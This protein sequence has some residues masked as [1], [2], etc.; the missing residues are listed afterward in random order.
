MLASTVLPRLA[1]GPILRLLYKHSR[2]YQRIKPPVKILYSPASTTARA[3][4]RPAVAQPHGAVEDKAICG[5]VEIGAEIAL[6]L[7]LNGFSVHRSGQR[8]LYSALG[9]DF[10]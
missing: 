8:G 6:A 10:K 7:E 4:L 2:D 1:I 9:Q 3:S 5:A